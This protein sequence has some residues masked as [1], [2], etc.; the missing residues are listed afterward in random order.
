MNKEQKEKATEWF[1]AHE[2]HVM[3]LILSDD[4]DRMSYPP[5]K[6]DISQPAV[7]KPAHWNWFLTNY[8]YN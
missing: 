8:L 6:E 5:T 2:S 7:W 3:K 4:A 1:R